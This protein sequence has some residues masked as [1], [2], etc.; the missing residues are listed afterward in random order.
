MTRRSQQAI[1]IRSDRARDDL[2][3]LTRDG[4]SQVHVVEQALALLRAQVEPRRDEAGE[5]RER[6]YA[7]LSRLAAIGG[8][9]MAEFD[10]AEYDEFGDPR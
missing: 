7:A 6:V 4:S 10:A 3:V 8:P 5:R 1:T 2:R 9:G